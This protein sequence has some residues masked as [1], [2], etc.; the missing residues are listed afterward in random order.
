MQRAYP[1]VAEPERCLYPDLKLILSEVACE[2]DLPV[3]IVIFTNG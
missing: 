1:E 2:V 3:S